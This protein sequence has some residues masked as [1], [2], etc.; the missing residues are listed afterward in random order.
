MIRRGEKIEKQNKRLANINLLFHVRNSSI[1]FPEEYDS[2][3]LEAKRKPAEETIKQYETKQSETEQRAA[4][5][6]MLTLQQML[7]RLPISLA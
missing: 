3:I 6:K 2:M 1:K 5:L 4:G 7:Q